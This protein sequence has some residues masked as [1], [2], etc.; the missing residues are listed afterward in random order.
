MDYFN[1]LEPLLRAYWY[2]AIPVSLIF[3]IQTILTF[4]GVDSAD[5]IDADFDGNLD[6]ADAPFQLFSFRNLINFLLG[7]SWAG[8]SFYSLITNKPLLIIVS[9]LV[10][11]G[12]IFLFFLI[13]KQIQKLAEN[14]TFKIESTL[15]K[16]ATVYLR[17]PANK[18]G[19]GKIQISINGSFREIDAI[20]NGES[21]ESAS[22]VTIISIETQNIVLV[23]R[24]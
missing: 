22:T 20:T 23:E 18:T 3:I 21:I 6:H 7:L 5:G 4:I 14:N 15:N 11:A 9:V 24:I 8:I 17:I 12:F 2:I 10:G 16:N 19:T 1:A 13:M